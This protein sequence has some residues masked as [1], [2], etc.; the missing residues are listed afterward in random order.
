MIKVR[1]QPIRVEITRRTA[2][3]LFNQPYLIPPTLTY[4]GQVFSR[5]QMEF[6]QPLGQPRAETALN[7]VAIGG[8]GRDFFELDDSVSNG[9]A[10]GGGGDDLFT[11]Y[12]ADISSPGWILA[13]GGGR[14]RFQVWFNPHAAN[15]LNV[16]ILDLAKN[17]TL[18]V[19]FGALSERALVDAIQKIATL[20]GS[21]THL[22]LGFAPETK[23]FRGTAFDDEIKSPQGGS[24][25]LAGGGNDD[26]YGSFQSDTL[27]GE[28]GQDTIDGAGGG[29]LISGGAG[30]DTIYYYVGDTIL[31]VD[32]SDTIIVAMAN[33]RPSWNT[34]IIY[35]IN[36]SDD[37]QILIG[38]IYADQLY[39]SGDA[40]TMTGGGGADLFYVNDAKDDITDPTFGD[41]IIVG[42]F[43]RALIEKAILVWEAKGAVIAFDLIFG[44]SPNGISFSGRNG[45]DTIVG[46]FLGDTIKGHGGND[47][48]QGIDGDDS[49]LGGA[50]HD[51]IYG[52]A[53]ND[54]L[55]G[56]SGG[57]WLY[58]DSGRDFIFGG[59]GDDIVN[60]GDGD[61]RIFGEGGNNTLS[62]GAGHDRML[63][64]DGD[65]IL[66]G[67]DGDDKIIGG[68]G[69]DTLNGGTGFDTLTGGRGRDVFAFVPVE[70][71]YRTA[72]TD[73]TG[74][75]DKIDLSGFTMA[76]FSAAQIRAAVNFTNGRLTAD[77]NRDGF[78]DL[79]VTLQTGARFN[80]ANDLV[81]AQ[82]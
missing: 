32:A 42:K 33:L 71:T 48:L 34:K 80:K 55:R 46:S 17:D 60:G 23:L 20:Y 51:V 19:Q 6:G 78:L 12:P 4:G 75:E 54:T 56:E 44:D 15:N 57:D 37:E 16:T 82:L 24:R 50:G 70:F 8:D 58:G 18:V 72:I 7:A 59:E 22:V 65:D 26:L 29:D 79:N 45:E 49:L 25:I 76:G 62:G 1:R 61:D 2:D 11:T 64:G 3:I 10:L 68:W 13:G 77:F 74:G 41:T 35:Q 21:Q 63:G 5:L 66:L 43:D 53:G 31:D 47:S 38:G 73:F 39:A 30:A 14:D 67:G 36:S 9:L 40:I 52:G 28:G 69:H 81:V 27:Y